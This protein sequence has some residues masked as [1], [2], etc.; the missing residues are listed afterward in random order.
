MIILQRR[1]Q[2]MILPHFAKVIDVL[3]TTIL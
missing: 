1:T 3:R 2:R